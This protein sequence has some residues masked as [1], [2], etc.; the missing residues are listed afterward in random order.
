MLILKSYIAI[1]DD[2]DLDNDG[3]DDD[4]EDVPDD[5]EDDDDYNK[6]DSVDAGDDQVGR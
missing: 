4:E 6:Y 3:D 1:E 2:V 5:D